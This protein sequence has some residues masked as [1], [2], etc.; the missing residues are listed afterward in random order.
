MAG[1]RNTASAAAGRGPVTISY[2]GYNRAWAAWIANR[3]E[4][5]GLQVSQQRWEANPGDSIEQT[6]RDLLLS[7]GRVLIVLS[8][9]YFR[10]GPRSA[11]EWNCVLREIVPA[12]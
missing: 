5:Q 9:W 3:L 11:D 8:E 7:E 10:L 6:L 1:G 4:R 12:N 2:A